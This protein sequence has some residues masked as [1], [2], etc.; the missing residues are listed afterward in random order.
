M[1]RGRAGRWLPG[2]LTPRTCLCCP[3][4]PSGCNCRPPGPWSIRERSEPG[5]WAQGSGLTLEAVPEHPGPGRVRR[6]P[7]GSPSAGEG[8]A[9]PGVPK[10]TVP[11]PSWA[12]S[13]GQGGRGATR[14]ESMCS[15]TSPGAQTQG[16]TRPLPLDGQDRPAPW[17]PS[18]WPCPSQAFHSTVIVVPF[19]SVCRAL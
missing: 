17:G 3:P 16:R 1:W 6:Q 10:A 13:R 7:V 9:R 18:G 2:I 5:C 12:V 15:G 11:R 19:K 4:V 8:R 14:R